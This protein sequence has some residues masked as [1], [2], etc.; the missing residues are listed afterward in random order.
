MNET[1]C[2]H[3]DL[4]AWRRRYE[5]DAFGMVIYSEGE[6]FHYFGKPFGSYNPKTGKVDVDGWRKGLPPQWY[7]TH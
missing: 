2:F 3:A 4:Y 1:S 6:Y 7:P 5:A